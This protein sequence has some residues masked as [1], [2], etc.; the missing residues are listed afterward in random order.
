MSRHLTLRMPDQLFKEIESLKPK[1]ISMSAYLVQL[2]EQ[3]KVKPEN[4]YEERA[5]REIQLNTAVHQRTHD[6]MIKDEERNIRDQHDVFHLNH[7]RMT[8]NEIIEKHK[9]ELEKKYK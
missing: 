9:V 7:G 1:K 2:I 3:G 4:T 6:E 5:T 8:F